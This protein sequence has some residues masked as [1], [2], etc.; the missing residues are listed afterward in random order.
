MKQFLKDNFKDKY[1]FLLLFIL[2]CFFL[3]S[4]KYSIRTEL[5]VIYSLSAYFFFKY[6]FNKKFYENFLNSFNIIFLGFLILYGAA[7]LAS[8]TYNFFSTEFNIINNKFPLLK[9]LSSTDNFVQPI[10]IIIVSIFFIRYNENKSYINLFFFIIVILAGLNGLYAFLEVKIF[11]SDGCGIV[12]SPKQSIFCD[13][14]AYL[15]LLYAGEQFSFAL[16]ERIIDL[17]AVNA[18]LKIDNKELLSLSDK[19]AILQ[20]ITKNFN[21]TTVGWLSL[22][23]GRSSGIFAMPI[24]AG[25]FH[26]CAIFIFFFFY[27]KNY[28]YFLNYKFF[29]I[30]IIIIFNFILVGAVLS[31]SKVF[32]FITLFLLVLNFFI[33]KKN[34]KI[35]SWFFFI[36]FFLFSISFSES[37]SIKMGRFQSL[38]GT[39]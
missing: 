35:F 16:D 31:V 5:I 22:S 6:F 21:S 37:I 2:A 26:S 17:E 7:I 39:L 23:S 4:I 19:A 24:Q 32:S 27:K 8:I 25:L 20:E 3:P 1:S 18:N 14:I 33:F 13:I 15:D 38:L 30:F 9:F 12:Y 36:G 10:A 11:Q 34:I 28:E 29:N